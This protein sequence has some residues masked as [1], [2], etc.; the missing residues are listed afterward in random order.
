MV[1]F[2]SN[3]GGRFNFSFIFYCMAFSIFCFITSQSPSFNYYINFSFSDFGP[4]PSDSVVIYLVKLYIYVFRSFLALTFSYILFL[5][6]FIIAVFWSS[7]VTLRFF[8][9]FFC[10][11]PATIVKCPLIP[12][13][14]LWLMRL[15][16]MICF[17]S[18]FN[19]AL[20]ADV[21]SSNCYYV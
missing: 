5:N 4:K 16:Y 10:F 13:C 20:M 21:C 14:K 7:V 12:L 8:F 2:C 3:L 18:Y 6:L 17:I 1:G 19:F 15:I 11:C 9:S